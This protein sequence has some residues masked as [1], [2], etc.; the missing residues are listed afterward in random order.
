MDISLLEGIFA[1]G[2]R[3]LGAYL[4]S[5]LWMRAANIILYLAASVEFL[6]FG[7]LGSF[8]RFWVSGFLGSSQRPNVPT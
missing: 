1:I 6:G 3:G 2:K 8:Q 7:F 4:R 5:I